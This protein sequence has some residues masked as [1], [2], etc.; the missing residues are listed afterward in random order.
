VKW[1]VIGRVFGREKPIQRLT[2][3]LAKDLAL[4]KDGKADFIGLGEELE[5]LPT[6]P[7]TIGKNFNHQ[8][9]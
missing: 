9:G 1:L 3:K 5:D 2:A 8:L 4:D 6:Y 7:A